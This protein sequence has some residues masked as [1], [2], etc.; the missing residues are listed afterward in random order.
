MEQASKGDGEVP[1]FEGGRED[2]DVVLLSSLRRAPYPIFIMDWKLRVLFIN[3]EFEHMT[4][5]RKDDV[6]RNRLYFRVHPVDKA[7]AESAVVMALLGR[8]A[9]C[10]C[11]LRVLN[12]S[13]RS[14][15]L[16]FSPLTWEGRRLVI[17]TDARLDPKK[18]GAV[19]SPVWGRMVRPVPVPQT[20]QE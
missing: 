14:L 1:P 15:E 8:T 5:F 3:L 20:A 10:R 9:Q 16:V 12:G 7:E 2:V 6:I 17:C 18:S 19:S 11:R 13:H 4:G